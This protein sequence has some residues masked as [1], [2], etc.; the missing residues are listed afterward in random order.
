MALWQGANLI[1]FTLEVLARL[2]AGCKQ[3]F[4]HRTQWWW[5][6]LDLFLLILNYVDSI[7]DVLRADGLD[8]RLRA[9]N[10]LR[11][12]RV[13]RLFE[14]FPTL[15]SMIYSI[16][17]CRYALACAI[18]LIIVYTIGFSIFF[19]QIAL[20]YVRLRK[21]EM[22][23]ADFKSIVN[24]WNGVFD[25][26]M[27]L[28]YAVTGG[29]SWQELTAP[30]VHMGGH[31]LGSI[32]LA[33]FTT[34]V[35]FTTI[36]LLNVLTGIFVSQSGDFANV[37]ID[38]A[39]ERAGMK[40]ADLRED[41]DILFNM[42]LEHA[43][44]EEDF[45]TEEQIEEAV[46]DNRIR[47]M[48]AYLDIDLINPAQMVKTFDMDQNNTIDRSEFIIGCMRLQGSAKPC[49]VQVIL[50]LAKEMNNKMDHLMSQA[51]SRRVTVP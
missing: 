1:F 26:F 43:E 8:P 37:S 51:S 45:L 24:N 7:T 50:G 4:Q 33:C 3:F 46:K 31:I 30:F 38:A 23:P 17:A 2:M 21:D 6:R 14:F 28:V 16:L 19:M 39:I 49:E 5:N 40:K 11:I 42:I 44:S 10:A 9:I 27:S 41:A 20:Y 18:F 22:R 25:A 29:V 12:L 36:G 47:S 34:Y 15:Q 35:V 13:L 32:W 48:Y